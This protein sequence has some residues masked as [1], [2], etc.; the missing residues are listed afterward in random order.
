[1]NKIE[2]QHGDLLLEKIAEIPDGANRVEVF[3]GYVLE[4]G[5]GVHTHSIPDVSGIQVFEKNGEIFVRVIREVE[6]D[7]EEHGRQTVKPGIYRKRIERVWDY[8][9]EEARKVVD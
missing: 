3:N 1:M 8:E 7:H 6:L 4:H 5:E 9:S 2:N